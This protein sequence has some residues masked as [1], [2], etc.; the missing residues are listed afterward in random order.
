MKGL[1]YCS[2]VTPIFMKIDEYNFGQFLH[3]LRL[4]A[5][6]LCVIARELI[7]QGKKKKGKGQCKSI[8]FEIFFH[9]IKCIINKSI[10]ETMVKKE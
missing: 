10:I 4:T 5:F 3:P 2:K 8:P 9:M 6:C 1:F 7:L